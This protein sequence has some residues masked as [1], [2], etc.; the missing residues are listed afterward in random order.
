MTILRMV[1]A[2]TDPDDEETRFRKA[3]RVFDKDDNGVLDLSELKHVLNM[4][5]KKYTDKEVRKRPKR[6]TKG[7]H[8]K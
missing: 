1:V 5:G 2:S 3:F 4:L 7:P 6:K 8:A